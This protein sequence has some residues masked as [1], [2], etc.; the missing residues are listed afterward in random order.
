[1][2]ALL[3]SILVL[4]SALSANADQFSDSQLNVERASFYQQCVV[5]YR[6]TSGYTQQGFATLCRCSAATFV[7]RMP[8]DVLESLRR[9][10][11][12]G[13]AVTGYRNRVVQY[14]VGAIKNRQLSLPPGTLLTDNQNDSNGSNY[15]HPAMRG[16]PESQGELFSLDDAVCSVDGGGLI[17]CNNGLICNSDGSGL[18]RCN[19]GTHYSTD[20]SGLTRSN[21]GSS[22]IS[23]QGG[24]TRYS[25][26]SFSKT[27]QSGLTRFSDGSYCVRDTS[28]LTRCT[29]R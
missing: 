13:Q 17:R 4:L 6:P 2:K 12:T 10:D 1:M 21:D 16:K 22:A 18:I 15:S 11:V 9:G 7:K 26:G 8:S 24:L 23:D 29:K 28:G 14:C 5:E 20:Q 19:D 27:D 25:N 3:V